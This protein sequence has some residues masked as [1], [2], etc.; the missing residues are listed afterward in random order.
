MLPL[1]WPLA[2]QEVLASFN[3][4]AIFTELSRVSLN[5]MQNPAAVE[6]VA[7]TI[8]ESIQ[9]CKLVYSLHDTYSHTPDFHQDHISVLRI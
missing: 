6:A 4:C 7:N 9:Q 1:L 3:H 8:C 5:H 2:D